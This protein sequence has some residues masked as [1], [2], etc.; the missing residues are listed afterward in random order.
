MENFCLLLQCDWTPPFAGWKSTKCTIN[1]NSFLLQLQLLYASLLV[2][3]T[4]PHYTDQSLLKFNLLTFYADKI[5]PYLHGLNC[6]LHVQLLLFC[7]CPGAIS[8]CKYS[9]YKNNFNMQAHAGTHYLINYFG[10]HKQAQ[11]SLA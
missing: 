4:R 3:Q 9:V 5:M 11:S 10:M 7:Y 8:T 2:L 6:Y 1:K